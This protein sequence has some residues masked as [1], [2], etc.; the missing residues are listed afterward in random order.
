MTRFFSEQHYRR[1]SRKKKI[2]I[3][4]IFYYASSAS[5]CVHVRVPIY[6]PIYTLHNTMLEKTSN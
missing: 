4:V 6:V 3:I 5:A 1:V 2:K